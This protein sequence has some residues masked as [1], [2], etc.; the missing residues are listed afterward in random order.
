M[1]TTATRYVDANEMFDRV[2]VSS[3]RDRVLVVNAIVAAEQAI[4]VYCGR[5]FTF[6]DDVAPRYFRARS[7]RFCRIDDAADIATVEVGHS[8]QAG[9]F[10]TF[11]GEYVEWQTN[12]GSTYMLEADSGVFP[13]PRGWVRVTPTTTWGWAAPPEVVREATRI[14]AHKWLRRKDSPDGSVMGLEGA[15]IVKMSRG[16]D[17]DVRTLLVGFRSTERM[18]P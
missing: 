10:A 4:D 1:S 5:T 7:A 17:D 18:A 8:T 13:S 9:T 6:L 14:Q 12:G 11:G 2:N 15:G 16:L 3:D